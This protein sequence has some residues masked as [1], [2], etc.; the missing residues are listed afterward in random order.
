MTW[1][2]YSGYAILTLVLFRIAWGVVGSTHARFSSFIY[3]PSRVIAYVF[4]RPLLR[5]VTYLGH[6][7]L[8][9]WMV[10]VLL[11]CLL[12]QA[13]TGLFANDDIVTDGPLVKWIS[14]ELSDRITGM[15]HLGFNVL[16]ALAALHIG[17]AL[18]Y[19]FVKKDNLIAPMFTGVKKVPEREADRAQLTPRML[20]RRRSRRGADRRRPSR[21][22]EVQMTSMWLAALL[23]V[24]AAALVYLLVTIKPG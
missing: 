7:A 19:L 21:P 12:V 20:D 16:L 5:S 15:H 10:V 3:G 24:L 4:K 17:G 2:M 22:A 23:L 11:V 13:G 8:G 6:N 1:H 18:F 9:G 14:K